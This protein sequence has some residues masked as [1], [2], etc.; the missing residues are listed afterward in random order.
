MAETTTIPPLTKAD[1]LKILACDQYLSNITVVAVVYPDTPRAA[2][3]V[4][5]AYNTIL[6]K[7]IVVSRPVFYDH[8]LGWFAFGSGAI[9]RDESHDDPS[10]R[11]SY[12]VGVF[13]P[14][15][16]KAFPTPQKQ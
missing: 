8:E 5:T 16:V 15:G 3:V 6:K 7:G 11:T 9:P 1:A 13:T 10:Q 12:Q 14:S 4:A 2:T